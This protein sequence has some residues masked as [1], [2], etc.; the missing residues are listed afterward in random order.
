MAEANLRAVNRTIKGLKE[1]GQL[2]DVP[3]AIVELCKALARA[4]DADPCTDCGTGQ[5]AAIYREY[6]AA[7]GDLREAA[8][9]GTDDDVADFRVSIQASRMRP[10][11]R[12]GED[13]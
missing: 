2:D 9:H 12:H 7:L 8:A 6:R 5:N 3:D 4:V 1:A 10:E 11:V 13:S